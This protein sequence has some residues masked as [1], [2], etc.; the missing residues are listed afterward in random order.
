MCIVFRCLS[1][2]FF[3]DA[4]PGGCAPISDRAGSRS[5]YASGCPRR[6]EHDTPLAGRHRDRLV[7]RHLLRSALLQRD[8]HLVLLLPVQL[9]RGEYS[10]Q[11][12][13]FSLFQRPIHSSLHYLDV[14]LILHF[15]TLMFC[16]SIILLFQCFIH[17]TL[18]YLDVTFILYFVT[19][20]FYQFDS[21]LLLHL[22]ILSIPRFVPCLMYRSLR[23]PT[24]LFCGVTDQTYRY[25]TTIVRLTY[26]ICV[27][28]CP[29]D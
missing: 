11:V 21:L 12:F 5:T 6:L 29:L 27:S 19:V 18:R 22:L 15:A 1:Y 7:Y 14:P 17:S 28:R 3:R 10:F 13:V 20:T 24:A 25:R 8:H 9:A 2:S 16:Q 4:N 23:H 26:A